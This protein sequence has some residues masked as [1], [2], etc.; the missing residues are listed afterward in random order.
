MAPSLPDLSVLR[1]NR[2]PRPSTVAPADSG[3]IE[4]G[5]LIIQRENDMIENVSVVDKAKKGHPKTQGGRSKPDD[6][7]ASLKITLPAQPTSA[8]ADDK[9]Y[10]Y[11]DQGSFGEVSNIFK[12]Y[13]VIK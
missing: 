13:E 10:C 3:E 12:I 2:P 6:V 5:G 4:G 11:C 8:D 1:T 7:E 9:T